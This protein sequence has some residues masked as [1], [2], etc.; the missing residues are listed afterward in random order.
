[1]WIYNV[2]Q[3]QTRNVYM[4]AMYPHGNICGG[5]S[6]GLVSINCIRSIPYCNVEAVYC[7]SGVYSWSSQCMCVVGRY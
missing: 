1:M 3:G 4:C 7:V 5:T 6:R 2:C